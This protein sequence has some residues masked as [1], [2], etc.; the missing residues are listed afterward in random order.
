MGTYNGEKYIDEQLKSIQT[1]DYDNFVCYIHDDNSDDRTIDIIKQYQ[2]LD[3]EHFKLLTYQT[4]KHG[5]LANFLSLMEYA[6]DNL[7]EE[8]IMFS[9]QDDVW[10]ET[11][12]SNEIKLLRNTEREEKSPVL[13]F[14]DQ[15]IVDSKLNIIYES[16]DKFI[17]R[18]NSDFNFK[19]LV[20]RN[21]A[22]GCT[23]CMNRSLLELAVK[24]MDYE[25]VIMHDWWLMLV[26][27]CTGKVVYLEKPLMLYRQH[28]DNTLGVDNNNYLYKITKYLF[29]FRV[30]WKAKCEQIHKC[31]EQIFTLGNYKEEFMN[32][33]SLLK[34]FC[35]YMRK[36]KIV[37]SLYVL[38]NGYIKINNFATLLFV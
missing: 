4:E 15:K 35:F 28:G 31:N 17:H 37:R 20:Y 2:K 13:A 24:Y 5:A 36:N 23:I 14:C 25:R 10:L 8:Y 7:K 21:I 16:F 30:S 6:N 3:P 9:D 1:Q 18:K 32:N 22:P 34:N 26:A 27:S 19:H 12:I 29:N 11:K 33:S 38:L